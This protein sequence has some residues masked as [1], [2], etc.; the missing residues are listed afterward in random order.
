MVFGKLSGI[1]LEFPFFD[2]HE[3][4]IDAHNRFLHFPDFTF[5]LNLMQTA[6]S[7]ISKPFNNKRKIYLK[8]TTRVIINPGDQKMIE[9]MPY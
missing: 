1:L 9:L 7:K 3:I 6:G 2:K 4:R 8:P 5:Q